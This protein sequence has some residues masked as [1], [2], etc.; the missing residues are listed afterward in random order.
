MAWVKIDDHFPDHPK[1]VSAGPLGAWLYVAGLC[2]C[3]R[4]LTDGFIPWSQV[5]R[6]SPHREDQDMR[7]SPGKLAMKLCGLGL[8]I[9]TERKGVP[10]FVVHDYK[11]YQPSRK[12]VLKE[13]AL[14]RGRQSRFRNGHRNGVSSSVINDGPVPVPV[15]VPIRTNTRAAASPRRPPGIRVTGFGCEHEPQCLTRHACIERTLAEGRR[16]VS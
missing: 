3:N 7:D 1:V 8:W 16:A 5:D 2:Y 10:G 4:L 13:R 15:P 9:E 6:L 11:K 14:N 12:Q